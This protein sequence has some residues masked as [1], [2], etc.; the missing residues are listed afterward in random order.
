MRQSQMFIP[1]LRETP[2]EAESLSHRLM[3]KS[4]MI[5]QLARGIYAYLP[6]TQLVLNNIQEI[7]REE[8]MNIGGAEVHLPVLHPR[9]LWEESGRWQAYGKE[10]MRVSD[11]H[12]REFALGPTHEEVI[13][14]LVRDELKSYKKLPL[15]LFQIQTK[16]RDELRPRFGL[17]RGREFIMKDAYS[18]HIDEESLD[19]TYNDMYDAYSRIFTRLD[20][21]FRA[22]EADGGSI[23]GSHTHE[24]MALADIGEDTIVYTDESSYAANIEKA[25]CTA[26][27][28]KSTADMLAAEK[29]ETPGIATVKDLAEFL[30]TDL[31]LTT[32]T[33]VVKT[34]EGLKMIVIRGD[35]ELNDVKVKA[36]FNS[37][38]IEMA[39]DEEITAELSASPGSLGPVNSSIPVYL[40]YQV[41][42]MRNYPV[43]ANE[44]G[45]H[46]LNVNHERDFEAAGTGDFRFINEGE[47]VSD[48][49]G[50]AK[51]MRG[52]E[53]GQVF[54]LGTKYSESMNFNVLDQ[55]GRAKPVLM[56]CY[57]IGISRVL[58]AIVES[59]HDEKGIFWPKSVT[60]FDIHLITANTKDETITN[61]ASELYEVLSKNNRVLYDDRNERAGVKFADS[62]LIGLPVRIVVGRGAK[63]GIVEVKG[64]LDEESTEVQI[65]DLT[66]YLADNDY[67]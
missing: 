35:Q 36:Y 17:L 28:E 47:M 23:G 34:D 43:G 12:D 29:I 18:F 64:R 58:S 50:A 8:M 24:F 49:S 60:P 4:G 42:A 9:E 39:T 57:G 48:G 53:V 66:S 62:E 52:I 38:I 22:V 37:E 44:T 26:P 1:T 5:K 59:H 32:K 46:I 63:D 31:T 11:R 67:A 54:K 2:T 16:F 14:A 27:K 55:N 25:E 21:N 7:V 30:N 19:K 6:I 56:G 65:T 45:Y 13:T 40:D 20:L 41:E 10:L 61:T 33:M 51:F 15:T 3:L